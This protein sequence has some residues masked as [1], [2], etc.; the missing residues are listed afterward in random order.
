MKSIIAF[1]KN[2]K[3]TDLFTARIHAMS[4]Y[5]KE[6]APE[7]YPETIPSDVVKFVSWD[8]SHYD[9]IFELGF[10]G[11]FANFEHF[12]YEFIKELYIKYPKSIPK[13]K[14]I[15]SEEILK[16][17][18]YKKVFENLVDAIAIENSYDIGTWNITVSK[19]FNIKPMSDDTK[20]RMMIMNSKRNM[21]LHSGGNWN[22]KIDKDSIK[23]EKALKSLPPSED[24]VS[25]SKNSGTK[26][27][28]LTPNVVYSVT[29]DCLQNILKDI[30]EQIENKEKRIKKSIKH[31]A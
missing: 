14:L 15:K 4:R 9:K 26:K 25:D 12:M 21:Y 8:A 17:T 2:L 28:G 11:I 20:V 6:R 29:M 13:D 19:L 3:S 7:K 22:S 31:N 23:I 27:S 24:K 10:I 16:F 1:E 5:L 18:S 30:K